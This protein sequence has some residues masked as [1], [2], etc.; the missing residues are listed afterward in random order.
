M[1]SVRFTL[2]RKE[3]AA[4]VRQFV[5]RPNAWGLGV[6]GI[7]VIAVGAFV[8]G[9]GFVSGLDVGVGGMCVLMFVMTLSKPWIFARHAAKGRTEAI[10]CFSEDS[11]VFETSARKH[12]VGWSDITRSVRAPGL[13]ILVVGKPGLMYTIPD[14][15]FD[16]S[17]DR[18]Q[19][20]AIA[21][22]QI[23]Q[24]ASPAPAPS[25]PLPRI[26]PAPGASALER[27][28]RSRRR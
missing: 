15:A 1:T 4:A 6:V 20:A 2:T 27:V 25:D 10:Y 18:E 5:L 22:R 26:G 12:I 16:S 13:T 19:F 14:R 23:K 28:F 3:Q 24:P 21:A 7:A 8:T 9:S 17:A 11:L